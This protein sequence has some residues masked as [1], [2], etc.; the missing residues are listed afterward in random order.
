[1]RRRWVKGIGK[2]WSCAERFSGGKPYSYLQERN[3]VIVILWESH[4]RKEGCEQDNI[5]GPHD[6]EDQPME[7]QS[8]SQL[9]SL[10]RKANS[11]TAWVNLGSRV[12]RCST[13][14]VSTARG[15]KHC[16]QLHLYFFCR[17]TGLC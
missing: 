9:F 15:V 7:D 5:A 14:G 16:L 6:S 10:T 17:C 1:M 4:L 11:P 12:S 2:G 8:L 13:A 3:K